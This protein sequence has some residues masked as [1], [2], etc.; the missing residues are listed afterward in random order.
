MQSASF[1]LINYQFNKV[2]LNSSFIKGD[3]IDISFDVGGEF[4]LKEDIPNYE[5][6]FEFSSKSGGEEN[7]F[8]TIVCV[9]NF[10]F[11]NVTSLDE[12][13]DYFYQNAIAILFPYIRAYVSLLTT[14][15][16]VKGIILPTL[17]LSQLSIPLKENSKSKS[18]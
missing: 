8:I 11:E 14:Q 15:A 10:S 2:E 7:K 6:S 5:L 1:R 17:N 9:A 12:I 4:S 16:N 13:P 18:K 3:D